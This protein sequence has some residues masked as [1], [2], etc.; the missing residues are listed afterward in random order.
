MEYLLLETDI[1][2]YWYE[3]TNE[4]YA[5]RQILLDEYG[6]I[7]ISCLEDCLAEGL[8]DEADLEG[9]I[10]KI[11]KEEF[12]SLW[13]KYIRK[14][15]NLWEET[16]KKYP[17]GTSVQ[18]VYKYFYPQGSI[19]KGDDFIA[20]YVGKNPFFIHQLVQYVVKAYDDMNMWLVLE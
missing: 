7:H 17:I 13:Y 14:Y 11:S 8:V 20:V 4:R 2:K 9:T 15:V 6:E 12:D 10:S 18:G 1:E 19:I 16:K 3:L 5:T